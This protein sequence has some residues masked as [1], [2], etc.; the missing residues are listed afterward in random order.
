MVAIRRCFHKMSRWIDDVIRIDGSHG[1]LGY[2]GHMREH[3]TWV[4]DLVGWI[5]SSV[6]MVNIRFNHT[7]R[8][9]EVRIDVGRT[10]VG[11]K[12]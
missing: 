7:A 9:M 11:S 1:S 10:W 2:H 12:E 4:C 3:W 5:I 6:I 8:R